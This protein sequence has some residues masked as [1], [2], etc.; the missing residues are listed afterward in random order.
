MWMWDVK[1]TVD[2][3]IVLCDSGRSCDF[4]VQKIR[5]KFGIRSA[6]GFVQAVIT[7]F[8]VLL[9]EITTVCIL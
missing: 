4:L 7:Y 5:Q 3:V 6:V 2:T 1:M 8:S 9:Q